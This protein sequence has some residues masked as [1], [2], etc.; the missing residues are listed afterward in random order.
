MNQRIVAGI[1][2]AAA[3]AVAVLVFLAKAKEDAYIN[4]IIEETGSCFLEDGTC[5]HDQRD[6][7]LYIGGWI[8]AAAMGTLGVYL[9]VFDR[10][11]EL[12][13]KQNQS[14]AGALKEA[15]EKDEFNA[16][17]SGFSEEEQKVL[18]AINEQDGIQ[19]STLRYRAGVSKAG[20]SMM[21]Q[22][23]EKKGVI[24]R[25]ASGKTNQVF[26]RKKF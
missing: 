10:Q 4:H 6:F 25:K 1:L 19:Q 14:I 24:S 22:S 17:L 9:L 7:S 3:I 8:I 13:V 18:R 15:S 2:I 26:L 16:F 23:F 5:L 20:L 12:L 11:E 21:L